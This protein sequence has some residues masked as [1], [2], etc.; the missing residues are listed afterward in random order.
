MKGS[1][2]GG[3]GLGN[4][5]DI[6]PSLEVREGFLEEGTGELISRRSRQK[7]K[8]VRILSNKGAK[9][10]DSRGKW[11]EKFAERAVIAFAFEKPPVT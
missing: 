5:R 11:K 3:Q 10:G 6:R 9:V 8:K 4:L 7:E 1:G 2:T